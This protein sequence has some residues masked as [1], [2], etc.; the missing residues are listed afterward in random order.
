VGRAICLLLFDGLKS[1]FNSDVLKEQKL[2][3]RRKFGAVVLL[4]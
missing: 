3:K 1:E 2:T 4:C